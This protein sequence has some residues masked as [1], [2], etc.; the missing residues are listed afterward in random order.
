MINIYYYTILFGSV[1]ADS[2]ATEI[3]FES[4]KYIIPL[5]LYRGVY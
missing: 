1:V 3:H 2:G 4:L 5:V